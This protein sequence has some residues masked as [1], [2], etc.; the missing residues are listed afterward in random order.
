MHIVIVGAGIVGLATAHQM[1]DQGYRVT[2]IDR[3]ELTA[4]WRGNAGIIA[5]IDILPLASPRMILQAAK[6]L[7]DP[8][9]PLSVR[10]GCLPRLLPWLSRFVLSALPSRIER[11]TEG[12][13]QLQAMALPAWERRLAS[14]GLVG[15]F[16]RNGI[17]YAYEDVDVFERTKETF[18]RQ[19]E[20]SIPLELIDGTVLR[21]M[22]PA[23]S[24]KPQRAAFFPSVAHV[25]DPY[26]L[27]H[28]LAMA[29]LDRGAEIEEGIVRS[30]A[31]AS[32]EE[33]IAVLEGGRSIAADRIV[34]A[35]GAW[36]KALA[37][38]LGDAVPLDTERGYNATMS[39][40]GINLSRPVMFE[41]HAFVLT[42][43]QTGLRIG[44]A[45]ELASTSAKPNWKRVEA[46]LAK[47]RRYVPD[48]Q[49]GGRVDFMGCRPSLPDS[50]PVIST[51][52][53]SRK[54]VYAFG[55]AHHG[56][57][58]SAATAE[59]VGALISDHAPAIDLTPYS[60]QRF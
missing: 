9:A 37:T 4:P 48:L 28:K 8:M 16:N 30:I 19:I 29:A 58:Q 51:S 27:T 3:G 42:P 44:G 41:E 39:E 55:H 53:W 31:V 45:V 15:E 18:R 60:A 43:L 24:D 22:E 59:L 49:E 2:L 56:L 34:V 52:R 7:L 1:L 11:S 33:P 46:L 32:G 10:P 38:S 36:S 21:S 14:L 23:L 5:H 12:I 17:L 40:P 54:V 20:L 6:W 25:N 13:I 47:A 26:D 50:L 57:T 35:A